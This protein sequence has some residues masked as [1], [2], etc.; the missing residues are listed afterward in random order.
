MLIF[1]W[2]LSLLVKIDAATFEGNITKFEKQL[3]RPPHK[4]ALLRNTNMKKT[5]TKK[6]LFKEKHSINKCLG[7]F[8]E[9]YRRA[10]FVINYES[11]NS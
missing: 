9:C 8:I 11:K 7:N 5:K 2:L 6:R 10:F 4:Q 3:T 1:C